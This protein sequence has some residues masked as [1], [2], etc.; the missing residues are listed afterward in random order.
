MK[1]CRKIIYD[2]L[3]AKANE[4]EIREARRKKKI[5]DEFMSFLKRTPFT[6]V[7]H[8]EEA[9]GL[10]GDHMDAKVRFIWCFYKW[11]LSVV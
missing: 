1:C 7:A 10:F 5:R 11:E 9:K 6:E 2:E 8:W 3:Y 4:R